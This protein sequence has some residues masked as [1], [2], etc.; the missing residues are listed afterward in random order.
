MVAYGS[1]DT[2]GSGTYTVSSPGTYLVAI[3]FLYTDG[4]EGWDSVAVT[5]VG[6]S[7][8]YIYCT[9]NGVTDWHPATPYI[10][11]TK[12][13]ETDWHPATPNIYDGGWST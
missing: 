11:C 1:G 8:A 12:D 4:T 5:V 10:Y 3:Y 2:S 9:K 7:N 13:G 6:A